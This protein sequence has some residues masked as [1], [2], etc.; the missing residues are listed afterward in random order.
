MNAATCAVFFASGAAALLLETLWFRQTGL[1]LGN[2]VWASALV[3]AGFMAG[4]ALGNAFA[5]RVGWSL[6]RPL[7]L[8]AALELVVGVT[9]AG[10]VLAMPGFGRALAP[11][12][13]R[14]EGSAGLDALRLVS[15]FVLLVAPASAMGATLPVLA[16]SLGARDT[17][18]GRLLGRLYGWN[19]LGA[20]AGALAGEGFLI[21]WLGVPGT[22]GVAAALDLAAALGA[23]VLD[24]HQ[25]PLAPTPRPGMAPAGRASRILAAAFLAGFLL[26]ALEVVWV[27]FL[28][29][30][31]WGTSEAFAIMLAVVLLGIGGGGLLASA[32]LGRR[33]GDRHEAT[34]LALAAGVLTV[35]SYATFEHALPA[36]G[37]GPLDASGTALASL[38]LMLPVATASGALF[39]LLGHSLRAGAAEDAQAAGVLTLANTVGAMLGSLAAGFV[40]LPLVGM[41]ASFFGVACGYGAVAALA[42]PGPASGG[43]PLRVVACGVL[44]VALLLFPFGVLRG[45]YVGYIEAYWRG[46]EGSRVVAVTE[47]LSETVFLLRRDRL[48]QPLSWRMLTNGTSMSTTDGASRRYMGLF[49]WLP[50]AL[51][52]GPRRALLISYGLGNTARTLTATAGLERID[53]VDVSPDVLRLSPAV[54]PDAVDNP[55]RDPR[56]CVHI[57]D[58]RFFLLASRERYDLIT[59]E[60]PPPKSA[61]I[62]NLYS[63]EYFRLM[64]ERLAEGGIA[65][66][67]LPA[68]H[69]RPRETFAVANAFCAAF[70]DCSLW[71][72]WGHE[73]M[74]LGTR[75]AHAPLPAERFA[76]QWSDPVVAARLRAAGFESPAQLGATFLADASTLAARGAG[77]APLVDD[78]PYRVDPRQAALEP[79]SQYAELMET[80]KARER[81]RASAFVRGRWPTRWVEASLSAFDG[82]AQLNRI[83]WTAEGVVPPG[84]LAQQAQALSG[85]G[86]TVALWALGSSV[87]E[88]EL[89]ARTAASGV[90]GPELFE[91][92]GLGAL[93][94]RDW[95]GAEA[96]LSRAEPH[97]A[98]APKLRRW[99]VLAAALAGDRARA[100]R[101]LDEAAPLIDADRSTDAA[102]AW[103]WLA[104]RTK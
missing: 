57:E 37:S 63:R 85:A 65:S 11:T 12:F 64:H 45:R 102:E 81:F 3:T 6:A 99:R 89:A 94:R 74:L 17:N 73:W 38:W 27:R 50:V 41:E 44:A 95:T 48:G 72:G 100:A 60:P 92:L 34:P 70:A 24:P 42:L 67:W 26:L 101:L 77:V 93:A 103:S 54:W 79:S 52:P 5:I 49:V 84:G 97:A 19:T 71:T 51:H 104:E 8:F 47:G 20:V 59:G 18:F 30:F 4:L 98:D 36:F 40:L 28:L 82:Q 55:L 90:T 16:R 62:V 96:L 83:A 86:P 43:R 32:W 69:L 91:V 78:Y 2:T 29:M 23:L 39:T 58:A 10:L 15:T 33:P 21:R 25:P 61:G 68:L 1:M 14:L 88:Q 35:A 80:G 7:R 53:V 46:L 76:R 87:E 31:A 13:S 22:A 9:G 56:V 66:Y 75:G